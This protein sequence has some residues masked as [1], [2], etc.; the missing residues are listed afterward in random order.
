MR[1]ATDASSHR[2]EQP[3]MVDATE[4][5]REDQTISADSKQKAEQE[6]SPS[7][8]AGH[9]SASLGRLAARALAVSRRGLGG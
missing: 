7:Q 1:A 5:N 3:Q 6:S 4:T 2:C 9:T 8:V